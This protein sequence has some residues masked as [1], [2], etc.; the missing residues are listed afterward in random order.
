MSFTRFDTGDPDEYVAVCPECEGEGSR[1][2]VFDPSDP[3]SDREWGE[4]PDC[5]GEGTISAEADD[6]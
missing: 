5:G 4:C 2:V 6:F 3:K 1:M